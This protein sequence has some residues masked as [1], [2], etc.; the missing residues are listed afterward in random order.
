MNILKQAQTL[1]SPEREA[2]QLMAVLALLQGGDSVQAQELLATVNTENLTPELIEKKK[3]LDVR[4]QLV[5]N[6]TD[7]A[8]NMLRTMSAEQ[9]GTH[10]EPRHFR[11]LLIAAYLRSGKVLESV[12]ERIRLTSLLDEDEKEKNNEAIWRSLQTVSAQKLTNLQHS[13]Q[14]RQ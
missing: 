5:D 7:N 13:L 9:E 12:Q 4:L 1:S 2:N 6:K 14:V 10:I 3:L 11:E 8:L